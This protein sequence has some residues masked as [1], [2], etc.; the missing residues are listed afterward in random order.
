MLRNNIGIHICAYFFKTLKLIKLNQPKTNM[1]LIKVL[2]VALFFSFTSC[3]TYYILVASFKQ[4]SAGMEAS[5]M[6]EVTTRGPV[7]DKVKYKAYPID[8]IQAVDK[9]GK[10][11]TIPNIPSIE[12]RF[13][14]TANKKTIFYFDMLSINGDNIIGTQSRFMTSFK[15]TISLKSIKI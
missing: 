11:V 7:G 6:R 9:S 4:Q 12:I 8:N 14:D 1:K 5:S 10:P 15:K 3:T 13:T 2:F